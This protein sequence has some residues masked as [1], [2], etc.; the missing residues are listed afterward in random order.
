MKKALLLIAFLYIGMHFLLAQTVQ[1]KGTVTSAEDGSPIP[2]ASVVVKGTTIGTITD[3]NGNYSLSAPSNATALCV[4][5]VGMKTEEVSIAGQTTINVVLKPEL[6]EID[7]VVV[8]ALGISRE[9][10]I[11]GYSVQD[12]KGEDLLK[13][14]NTNMI[15]SLNGKVSGVQVINSSGAAGASSF[16]TI[17]GFASITGDNQPLFVVDGVPIDNS[18]NYSGNPDNASN[19]LLEGVAYSNR[20][21]DLNPE[22]IESVSVLKGGAATALYG[23][24]AAN[25]VIVITTK[26]GKKTGAAGANFSFSSSLTFEKVNKLPELQNKFVQGQGGIYRNALTKNRY[27]WGPNADTMYW[28]N[29]YYRYDSH[30]NLVGASDPAAKEKF[31][32]YDNLGNFFKT[33]MTLHNNFNVVG[34]TEN[35]NYYLSI[36]NDNTKGVIPKNT[37][38]KTSIKL[39]AE[40]KITEKITVNGSANYIKSGGDRI[41]Q[42]SNLSGVMLGLLRTPISFDN[43][44]GAADPS[45]TD[46]AFMFEDGT[47]RSYRGQI[48]G[49]AI[50]DNPY[51]TVNKNKFKDDVDR[52]IGYIGFTVKILDWMSLSYKLGNDYSSDKRFGYFA[53]YSGANNEGQIQKDNHNSWD[54]NSDLILNINKNITDDINTNINVGHNIYQ[55]KYEQVYV[56]GNSLAQ[57]DFYHL[58]NVSSIV[59]R[60]YNSLYRTAAIWAS[61]DISYRKLA[62]ITLTGR[63]EW[64]TTLPEGN[65]SFFFPSVSGSFILTELDALKDN[66]ILSFGKI[67]ASWAQTANDAPVYSTVS[68]YEQ[69]A[70]G[71]GWTSGISFPFLGHT[72][73]MWGDTKGNPE[74]KPE[75]ARNIEA[76]FDMRLINSKFGIN[77]SYFNNKNKDL[78]LGVPVAA[79]SGYIEVAMNAGAMVNKGIELTLDADIIK[80][81]DLR[82]NLGINFTKIKNEVITLAEGVENVFL[83]GF[84]G[85]QIRAVVGYPYGS[86]F[87]TQF[88]KDATGNVVIDSR[89]SVGGDVNSEY[90][91]PMFSLEEAA[92]GSSLPD[93]TAGINTTVTFKGLSLYALID[94]KKGGIMWN[95]TRG[96]LV[97]FGMAKE[98]EDRSKT[99]VL[100]G[101]KAQL[102]LNGDFVYDENGKIVTDA[103]NDIEVVLDENWYN[104]LGGG[105]AGPSEQFIEKTNWI[106]LREVS[107][108]YSLPANL[109]KNTFIKGID[110]SISGRNLWLK[111]PYKGI[112]PETNLMGAD[113]AQGIDYFN[114]P[115]T[116]SYTFGIRLLF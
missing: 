116:K 100:V 41:Q 110:V 29:Q 35:S 79:T 111:T 13:V 97:S 58:S 27:S 68:T 107:I 64:S 30:G 15:N 83:G 104:G 26:K 69:A 67:R 66:N 49:S 96:A 103:A 12:V 106:R 94:I 42:G 23:I 81:S 22:D 5:F 53:K 1:I 89:D 77:F 17:R 50:Y 113:N 108:S 37:Y 43:A 33:G 3:A 90:G 82:W 88:E 102:D 59:S 76:G 114:M 80:T 44:N 101:R 91:F 93:W 14:P 36:T 9:K 85:A 48:N 73:Y 84:E 109:I 16:I 47:Q 52:L 99:A 71:D 105:F 62:N 25:G 65:N 19:N 70:Y 92:Y 40:S 31:V 20:A 32:P 51:W 74:L 95:G 72:G 55:S 24:R 2:G 112:D 61:A 6:K 54:I 8:T 11:L 75:F 57:P 28:D 98:T 21:I 115:G 78:I 18:M 86:I 38:Q 56:E 87:G 45:N 10:R 60:Q 34:G 63:Q 39:T 4:S 7:E 46:S